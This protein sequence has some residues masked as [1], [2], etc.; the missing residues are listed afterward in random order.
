MHKN[1]LVLRLNHV[2]ERSGRWTVGTSGVV[3]TPD[4]N[5]ATLEAARVSMSYDEWWMRCCMWP[6]RA[7]N[8]VNRPL[9]FLPGRPRMSKSAAGGCRRLGACG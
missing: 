8:D 9:I 6:R 3:V 2:F 7:F 4:D 5:L 1:K